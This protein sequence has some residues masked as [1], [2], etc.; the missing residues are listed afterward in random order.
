MRQKAEAQG[1]DLLVIDTG[2]RVEGNGLYDASLPKGTYLS[3]IV[4]R[5]HFDVI[6]VGNHELYKEE[7]AKAE[8][9]STVPEYGENYLASNLDI[10]DPLTKEVVPFAARFKRITTRIQ[11]IRI[12]AFGFL[13]NFEK[14]ANNTI[15][16]KVEETIKEDWF[17][18]A[19]RQPDVDLFLVTGHVP[20]QS[21]EAKAIIDEIRSVCDTPIQVLGGHYH[22]RDYAQ[23]DLRAVGLASGR[24]MET[25]GFISIDG[26]STRHEPARLDT[27]RFHRRY[28]DNNLFSFY[29]HTGLDD[30]TFPTELGQNTSDLIAESR[31]TLGLDKVYGCAPKSLWMSRAPYP[32]EDNIYT[33][34]EQV[35]RDSFKNQSPGK[36]IL[37]LVNTGSIRFD[38]FQGPITRDTAYIVSPFT[39]GFRI[40]SN[41][42]YGKAR[43]IAALLNPP[44]KTQSNSDLDLPENSI[45]HDTSVS[46][47]PMRRAFL[48][49]QQVLNSQAPMIFPGYITVDAA[50]TDGDDTI[51]SRIPFYDVPKTLGILVAADDATPEQ[52]DLV[53]VD[54]IEGKIAAA[55]EKVGLAVNVSR[56]SDIY[57]P[58]TTLSDLMIDW[59]QDNWN[60]H[61]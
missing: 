19:I 31:H 15:V 34:L 49:S 20:V 7:T 61:G 51:H 59:V 44:T 11:G 13:F 14:N 29:H 35:V 16:R 36:S 2:D 58:S 50:G 27:P 17:Q 26:L 28:I 6:T 8:F 22:I 54:F 43:Q 12:M 56:D 47:E 52:V 57:M 3:E 4:A 5:Q 25:V 39:S 21:G 24:F 46:K 10:V 9:E 45:Y 53:Y 37:A 33:W 38:V 55:A 30:V 41:I 18:E 60:C 1:Q 48:Q 32:G 42:P 23:Y 40:L